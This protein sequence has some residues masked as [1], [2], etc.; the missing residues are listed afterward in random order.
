MTGDS[1]MRSE[2]SHDDIDME[3]YRSLVQNYIGLVS[4]NERRIVNM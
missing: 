1:E 4:S 2:G 3:Y